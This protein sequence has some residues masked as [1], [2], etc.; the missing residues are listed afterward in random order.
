MEE[1]HFLPVMVV[2]DRLF[3]ACLALPDKDAAFRQRP[4]LYALMLL[5]LP[6]QLDFSVLDLTT[7]RRVSTM[8]IREII[9]HV[10]Y[11]QH[12]LR[13]VPSPAAFKYHAIPASI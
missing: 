13:L 6:S 8:C 7:A 10:L 2:K 3:K 11:P 5:E 12:Q 4:P 1:H 9:L